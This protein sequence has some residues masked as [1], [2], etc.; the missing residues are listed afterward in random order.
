MLRF[1]DG[2]MLSLVDAPA[3]RETTAVH[4]HASRPADLPG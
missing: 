2:R 1:D 4:S 3:D